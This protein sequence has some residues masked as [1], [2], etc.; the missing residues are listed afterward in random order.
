MST[1]LSP[2]LLTLG[3]LFGAPLPVHAETETS[4]SAPLTVEERKR[5]DITLSETNPARKFYVYALCD[6]G[7]PFYIGKGEGLRVLAHENDAQAMQLVQDNIADLLCERGGLTPEEEARY[8]RILTEKL[9]QIRDSKARGDFSSVIIKWGLTSA[10]AF[11]CESALIN[12]LRTLEGKSVLPLTNL[13]NGHASD[14][15]AKSVA[16]VKTA[17]RDIPTF[18]SECAVATRELSELKDLGYEGRVAIVRINQLYPRCIVDGK[19][20]P[21]YV[22]DCTRGAWTIADWRLD[23]L[24]Y[25][26]ALYRSRVVGIYRITRVSEG[27]H[28]EWHKSRL[29]DFP[30]FPENQRTLDRIVAQYASREEADEAL[31]AAGKPTVGEM[32][33]ASTRQTKLLYPETEKEWTSTHSRIY[34][35]VD[36]VIP[37]D[38]ASFRNVLL[39]KRDA[40]GNLRIL[41]EQSALTYTLD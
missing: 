22:K 27:L 15:E 28:A 32:I 2:L 17:A 21:D 34:F 39:Q 40:E 5:L 12:L 14:A 18:L 1:R 36:D 20:N 8:K 4:M 37:E 23:S 29:L 10:E 3:L 13:V 35:S 7:V 33:A 11:M 19:V 9:S 41:N 26:I 24:K 6:R 31:A 16:N 38:L 30:T 25:L